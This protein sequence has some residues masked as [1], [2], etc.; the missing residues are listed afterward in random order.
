L[1]GAGLAN[2]RSVAMALFSQTVWDKELAGFGV[3]LQRRDPS[4]VLK[5]VFRS[6]Q[7]FY[8]IGRYGVVTVDQARTEARRLLGLVA[9]GVDPSE[10]VTA[11]TNGAQPLTVAHLCER[12]LADGPSFKPDK[13][14]SSGSPTGRISPD[15]LFRYW[16]ASPRK[17]ST[18]AR[19]YISQARFS[20][21]VKPR[22]RGSGSV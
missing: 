20:G 8:M 3:R 5:Y 15:T 12:Y 6:R 4:F 7:R 1:T 2:L 11:E 9:S 22:H 19:R 16:G 10:K 21:I 17:R 13:K 14:D 18:A